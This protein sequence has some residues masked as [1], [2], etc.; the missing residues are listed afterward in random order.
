MND[1]SLQLQ[2]GRQKIREDLRTLIED[3]EALLRLTAS[4]SGEQVDVLRERMRARIE[5][6]KQALAEASGVA[7]GKYRVAADN[8]EQYVR[9][10]PWQA[11]GIGVG[12]GLL[13]GVLVSR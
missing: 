7:R 11:I 8:T 5:Q 13:L 6:A 1:S 9:D 4:V 3:S 10:N 2:W 12:V